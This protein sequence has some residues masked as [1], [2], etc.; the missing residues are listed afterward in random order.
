MPKFLAVDFYCGAGGTTRGLLDAG[1][2][3]IAGIDKDDSC[4][5]TYRKN[6]RNSTLNCAKPKFIGMDM[7]PASEDYPNGQQGDV[8]DALN[9]LIPRYRRMAPNVPLLFAICAPCQSFTKFVQ[10]RMTEERTASRD[11]DRSLLS[12]TVGF[13]EEFRPDMSISE[14]VANIGPVWDDFQQQIRDLKYTTGVG[15]VCASR[16]GVPQYRRR[17]I[18]MA[19]KEEPNSGLNFDLPVPAHDSDAPASPS[20]RDAIGDLPPLDAGGKDP[21]L[22]NHECHN[23]TNNR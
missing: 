12:Q 5:K 11:R 13:I 21:S 14:N 18:L 7:F 10:R 1:G 3:V 19:V 2:Y 4:R 6:N 16:F 17:S 23:L 15:K 8:W 20:V 9:E 22:A